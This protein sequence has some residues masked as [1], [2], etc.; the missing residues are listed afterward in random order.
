VLEPDPEADLEVLS[1]GSRERAE[2]LTLRNVTTLTCCQHVVEKMPEAANISPHLVRRIEI[3]LVIEIDEP[4]VG[5]D[6]VRL[7]FGL[8]GCAASPGKR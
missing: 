5:R 8:A 4:R 1:C 6:S 7:R 3:Q 2:P